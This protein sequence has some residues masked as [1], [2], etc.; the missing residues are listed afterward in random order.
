M[1]LPATSAEDVGRRRALARV[2]AWRRGCAARR[3]AASRAARRA[4]ARPRRR[5][6]APAARRA[7]SASASTAAEACVPLIRARPSFGRERTGASPARRSASTPR[8][9]GP[10]VAALAGAAPRPRRSAPAPG[11][12]AARGR[13]W[14]RPIRG[15]AR[16]GWT[17]W[18]SSAIS[19]VERL[20]AD[21]REALGEHVGP[22]RHHRAHGGDVQRFAHARG[23]AAQQVHLQR[24]R[25]AAAMRTS[26]SE[27]KPVLMP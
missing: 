2:R 15:R 24:P 12:R 16:R 18:L 22:Q 10:D 14:R 6:P 13:R 20:E 11:G 25:S 21:A 23:M 27:P 4:T 3:G 7:R 1:P 19:G 17:P 5:R 9:R 26:A 8:R